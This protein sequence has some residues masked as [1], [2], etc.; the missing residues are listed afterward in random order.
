MESLDNENRDTG[1]AR[2]SHRKKL[3]LEY[4]EADNGRVWCA[5]RRVELDVW[6]GWFAALMKLNRIKQ[7]D[8]WMPNS[9]GLFPMTGMDC[10]R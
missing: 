7:G 3:L 2:Y 6:L 4:V 1:K 5:K 9:G 10:L 8:S